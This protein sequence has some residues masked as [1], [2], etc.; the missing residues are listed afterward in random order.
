VAAPTSWSAARTVDHIV[1]SLIFYAGQ[2]VRRAPRRLPVVRDGRIALPS[3]QLDNVLTA[4]GLL[5]VALRDLGAARAWHPSGSADGAG[6]S[7]MAVTEILVHGIDTAR[8]LDIE[9][10]LPAEVC[11]RTV[12]RVFPWVRPGSAPPADLLAA[13]TGRK[14]VLDVPS[15]PDW[16][17][18]SAPLDEWDGQ[19]RRRDVAPGWI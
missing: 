7:G 17:W 15:D 19:P 18:Q 10:D 12:A 4:A 3:D 6:W 11:A 16:W 8:A 13:V 9:L 2:V 1:D 5:M 14:Q